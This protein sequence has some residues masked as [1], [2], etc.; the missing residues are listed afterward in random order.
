[1]EIK[2]CTVVNFSNVIVGRLVTLG[3]DRRENKTKRRVF[4][5]SEH[6]QFFTNTPIQDSQNHREDS[7][8][9][10]GEFFELTRETAEATVWPK[11]RSRCANSRQGWETGRLGWETLCVCV[12]LGMS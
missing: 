1:M 3:D 2:C 8:D 9:E 5:A 12:Y 4:H 10:L 11:I 6:K 7:L